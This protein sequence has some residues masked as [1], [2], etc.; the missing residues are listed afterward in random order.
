MERTRAPAVGADPYR[1]Q[2]AHDQSILVAQ[3]TLLAIF[4]RVLS[5]LGKNSLSQRHSFVLPCAPI[6]FCYPLD[7]QT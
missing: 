3:E 4:R 6:L 2:K 7:N 1:R 5:V